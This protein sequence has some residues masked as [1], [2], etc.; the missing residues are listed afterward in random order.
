[1]I[2]NIIG[3]ISIMRSNIDRWSFINHPTKPV[4]NDG[5]VRYWKAQLAKILK[6]GTEFEFNLP[7]NKNGICKGDSN[8][9]PCISMTNNDCWMSCINA[10]TC[11]IIRS[12]DRCD[13]RT[14]TC[15]S[16]DCITCEHFKC[17]CK[18]IFCPNFTTAC[19]ICKDF[20]LNCDK[21]PFKYD[22][23]KDP[24]MIRKNIAAVLK[25]NNS[26][27][28]VSE[29]GVHSITTDGSL[30]GKKGI[31]IITVGRR[32]DY[33]EFYNMS[34]KVIDTATSRGAFVN[35]RCSLHMHVLAA[36]YGKI[37]AGEKFGIP[38]RINEMEKSLPEIIV[39]NL[40]QLIR[41]YQNAIT[42]MTMG[43]DNPNSMTRWEKFRV[44][45]LPISA[46]Y[47]SMIKVRDKVSEFA[48]GN[49]YGWINYSNIGF[50]T[51]EN[52]KT[53][54]IEFR[55]ADCLICPSATAA[56][57]CLYYTLVIKAVEISRYGVLEV[58]DNKWLKHEIKIKDTLLNNTK[59][60]DSG[61]RFSNTEN[62]LKYQNELIFNSLELIHQLKH[63]LI[64][65]G[66]AYEV[67]EKLAERPIAL[68]RCGGESWTDIEKNLAVV[69]SKE[70]SFEIKM[71]EFI[72]LRLID[73]CK[74]PN[75][76]SEEIERAF[77]EDVEFKKDK[78][79]INEIT[80]YLKK[81]LEDGE[82]IWSN[83]I[84][85]PIKI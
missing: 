21:C 42:W 53:F 54:H 15:N 63:L 31:E 36:Y 39:S 61:D 70:D 38:T 69:T 13:N 17:E 5:E 85:A 16:K 64:K 22:I 48:G 46:I 82:I 2:L 78:N 4:L 14:G 9:C 25:P 79:L 20:T 44:S 65:I 77:K 67:L 7:N 30:T 57:A 19:F 34:K 1:M 43:L 45:V 49:K 71:N 84:G 32:I 35:E 6:I 37:A 80:Q 58:G 40:H 51:F 55:V 33:W 60:Y 8:S 10:D 73:D 23:A 52:I 28:I 76:W 66:P 41:K 47:N 24:D 29:F 68:R 18:N 12:P 3:G 50:D 59:P 56:L 74:N 26:Y 83:S 81:R 11:P 62:L 72:D 27:G 75:E